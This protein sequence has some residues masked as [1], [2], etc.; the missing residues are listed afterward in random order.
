M[1]GLRRWR[2]SAGARRAFRPLKSLPSC[3]QNSSLIR[4]QTSSHRTPV[5]IGHAGSLLG[6]MM[7][8]GTAYVRSE[9][10]W[11]PHPSPS[12]RQMSIPWLSCHYPPLQDYSSFIHPAEIHGREVEGFCGRRPKG[13]VWFGSAST[14]EVY[15][16]IND[17]PPGGLSVPATYGQIFKSL[18]PAAFLPHLHDLGR[19]SSRGR[20]PGTRPGSEQVSIPLPYLRF[21]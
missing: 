19:I 5:S 1:P 12:D 6:R 13:L 18:P 20:K 4:Q 15:L 11:F 9:I 2:A 7:N 16:Y 21:R 3:S 14:L 10:D 17:N 8:P